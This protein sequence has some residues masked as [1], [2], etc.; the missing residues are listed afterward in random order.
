L[1]Y[2]GRVNV[3]VESTGD[4]G[5]APSEDGVGH[6]GGEGGDAGAD[7]RTTSVAADGLV[8]MD[9]CYGPSL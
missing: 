1:Q 5:V 9:V 3:R 4:G 2:D 7:A 8:G 6:G